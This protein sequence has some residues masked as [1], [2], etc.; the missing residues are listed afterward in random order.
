MRPPPPLNLKPSTFFGTEISSHRTSS[1]VFSE[2]L[3]SCPESCVE[4]HRHVEAHFVYVQRGHY[5][6]EAKGGDS[7][8]GPST[9]IFNPS[10]T[11]HRDRFRSTDG[12]FLTI[13][14][15]GE[16]A[17]LIQRAV[18]VAT[19]I[20]DPR[21]FRLVDQTCWELSQCDTSF[22][23]MLEGLGL[24]ICGLA[25]RSNAEH[26]SK[27]PCWLVSARNEIRENCTIRL[28]IQ[29]IAARAG[30]HPVYL[31]RAFRRHFR[32][33]PGQ[34]HRACRIESVR[35][36]LSNSGL[37]LAEVAQL[38]GFPDQSQLTHQFKRATGLTPNQFRRL[39]RVL[40]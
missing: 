35:S 37:P 31:A 40:D 11:T 25:S 22:E 17:A 16:L 30:V 18:P 12:R 6:T 38:N 2:M 26:D 19:R 29:E 5:I 4:R 9:L 8:C 20:S 1:F 13:S 39:T 21:L 33:S 10:N 28:F 14:V 27:P 24:E 23:L 7:L 34:Y 36:M 32:C 3:G 15:N